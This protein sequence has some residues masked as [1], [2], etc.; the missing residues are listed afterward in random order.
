[1]RELNITLCAC[2]VSSYGSRSVCKT[3]GITQHYTVRMHA[4]TLFI[5]QQQQHSGII[6][7]RTLAPRTDFIAQENEYCVRRYSDLRARKML[8]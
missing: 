3:R 5:R 7:I 1:M 2:P 6:I 4:K 8:Q